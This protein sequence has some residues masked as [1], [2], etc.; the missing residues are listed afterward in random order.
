MPI[1]KQSPAAKL[2]GLV[3]AA[4]IGT[5][6]SVVPSKAAGVLRPDASTVRIVDAQP[7]IEQV[8][9]RYRRYHGYRNYHYPRFYFSVG[10]RYHY[11]RHY[12]RHW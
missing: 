7:T 11:R 12:Y 10:P 6:G 9:W 4:G 3:I 5:V 8:H 2:A 1:T